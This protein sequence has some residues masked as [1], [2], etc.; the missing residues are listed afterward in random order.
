M[1]QNGREVEIH[2]FDPVASCCRFIG[3]FQWVIFIA[4]ASILCGVFGWSVTVINYPISISVCSIYIVDFSGEYHT[5][6]SEDCFVCGN[7]GSLSLGSY[8]VDIF[9]VSRAKWNHLCRLSFVYVR[10]MI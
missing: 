5:I 1:A 4:V 8:G 9:G 3:S 10:I 7:G 6:I 2:M